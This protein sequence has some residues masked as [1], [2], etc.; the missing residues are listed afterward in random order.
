MAVKKKKK[1]E[2][3]HYTVVGLQYRV[4]K[5]T[6]RML[7]SHVPF[8]V[9]FRREKNNE[10]DPNAIAVFV[11]KGIP[12]ADMHIGYLRRQVAEV[13]APKLDAGEINFPPFGIIDALYL[14]KGEAEVKIAW[15]KGKSGT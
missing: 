7:S 13:L 12:Y 1:T 8:A 3:E 2:A 6:R 15:A 10:Y 4:P 11:A 9:Y 14:D 5:G